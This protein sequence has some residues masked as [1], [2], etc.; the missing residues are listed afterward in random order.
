MAYRIGQ[1][2]SLAA[3]IAS[4]SV[5][6]TNCQL[7]GE[8]GKVWATRHAASIETLES[9]LPSGSGFDAGSR[10]LTSSCGMERVSIQ[11]SFHHMNDAGGYDGWTEHTVTGLASFVLGIDI[12]VSGRNRNEIKDYIAELFQSVLS[13][14][15]T[16]VYDI[17][18]DTIEYV[19]PEQVAALEVAS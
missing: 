6:L 10:I 18:C 1:T 13:E 8:D 4:T 19:K 14:N 3:H 17:G 9:M 2:R 12:R 11:T 15:W 7:R 16:E 5:A